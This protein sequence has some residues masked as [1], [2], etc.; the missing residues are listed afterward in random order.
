MFWFVENL[1]KQSMLTGVLPWDFKGPAISQQI[2]HDKRERQNWYRDTSVVHHFYTPLEPA[3]PNMRPSK[4]NPPR[5]IHALVAEYDVKIPPARVL[6]AIVSMKIKP[7]WIE[8]SLGGNLRLVW[9]LPNPLMVESY[10]FCC[11]VLKKAVK[12]LNLDLLPALDEA[13]FTTPTRLL[14]NGGDWTKT[15]FDEITGD[16]LQAFFVGCAKEFRFKGAEG[17]LI[18]LDVIEAELKKQY[19]AFNWPGDFT[20]DSQG[21]TFWIPESTSPLSAILKPEGLITF[22]AHA[23]KPFYS[24]PDLLGGEFVRGFAT[25]CIAKATQDIW[26]DGKRFWRKKG[27]VYTSL[28]APELN[29]YF[30]VDCKLSFKPDGSGA[31]QAELALS[32]IYTMNHVSGAAPFVFRPPGLLDFMG[33]RVLNT[34]SNRVIPPAEGVIPW[35]EAF[36]FIASLLDNLFDPAVQ[37]NHFLAWWKHFYTAAFTN[38]PD[39]GQNI[40]LMGGAGVG[41]SLLNREIVGSSVGGHVDASDFLIRGATFNSEL[42][43]APLWC[44]DDEAASESE[45]T[46]ANFASMLKK[47]TANQT[48]RHNKKFEVSVM[49]EWMG[50]II[51]TTNLDYVSSRLLVSLDNTSQD[52]TSLFKCTTKPKITFPSRRKTKEIIATE[53]P[54]FLRWL[55]DWEPSAEIARNSRYGYAPHH[56]P[57]LLEKSQQGSRSSPFKELLV[58]SLARWFEINPKDTEW[59]GSVTQIVRLLHMDPLNEMVIRSLKLEQTSRYLE[60]I[61]REGM[62]EC[63]VETGDLKQRIWIFSRRD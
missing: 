9:T 30:K 25:Q 1:T 44:V 15:A 19:P 35:G 21:P 39:S 33:K 24:W 14:C 42:F 53:L 43:D 23:L 26:W 50:R 8:R 47:M 62:L 22:A 41:K 4:D 56:E 40:F 36:P 5:A 51:C 18:P 32:H 52:K 45:N 11:F 28:D 31:S 57:S 60:A 7:A 58:E 38:T 61:Q 10:D 55:L 54:F 16:A 17:P 13:A 6:E 3:N 63:R 12:W 46:R 48:F 49:T 2:R 27:E 59:K 29:N 37:L 20:E 34:Y